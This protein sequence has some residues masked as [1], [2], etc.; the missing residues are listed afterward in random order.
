[1]PPIPPELNPWMMH[2]VDYLR[3]IRVEHART[4][5]DYDAAEENKTQ[6]LESLRVDLKSI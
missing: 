3:A 5:K 2:P 1:M 4:E 6:T